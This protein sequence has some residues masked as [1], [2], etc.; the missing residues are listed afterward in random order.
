MQVPVLVP[1]PSAK[2]MAARKTSTVKTAPCAPV[3][4]PSHK[5]PLTRPPAAINLPKTP[6]KSQAV[7]MTMPVLS[8][9]PRMAALQ[10]SVLSRAKNRPTVN[11]SQAQA[12]KGL[13]P[14]RP[15]TESQIRP[16][17]RTARGTRPPQHA[18][19]HPQCFFLHDLFS[20]CVTRSGGELPGRS[21]LT[22]FTGSQ[23]RGRDGGQLRIEATRRSCGG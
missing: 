10:Y 23:T 16:M 5:R 21:L 18:A 4:M 2:S 13:V 20:F 22:E 15:A 6:A 3:V 17:T 14:P 19:V 1:V 8:P 12:Q 7:T 9:M 11:A